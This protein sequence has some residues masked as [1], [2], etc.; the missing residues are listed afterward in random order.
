MSLASVLF[1][2]VS[3]VLLLSAFLPAFALAESGNLFFPSP[4]KQISNGISPSNVVCTEGNSL[5]L[6]QSNGLP[7][8]V[9]HSSVEKLIMRGWAI[10]VLPDYVDE[11]NN[12][13]IFPLGTYLI[14]SEMIVYLDDVSGYLAKPI[15]NGNYPGI[16]M[17]HEWWGLNEN[18]KEMADKLASH[19]YIVLAVDLYG[20]KVA[21][22]SDQARQLITQFDSDDGLQNMNSAVLLLSGNYSVSNV[23]SIGWCFGGGQSLNLALASD[24]ID[25]TVI[26]YGSVVSDPEAL[27]VIDW[28]VLGVFA[29]LDKG[30]PVKSVHAFESA[31]NQAGVENQILI[32]DGVDHAFANPSGERFAP[33]ASKDAWTQTISFLDSN[34]K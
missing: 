21:T 14:T 7:A 11:N 12:S 2:S 29:E 13:E 24:N 28:P 26:Y 34:L 9:N 25:A 19:G 17:I 10:H 16:V 6:K 27:S 23:G 1:F 20:G 32:Y 30:I 31:L 4:L 8:C 5:V 15:D 22:T 18:I 33:D 3:S